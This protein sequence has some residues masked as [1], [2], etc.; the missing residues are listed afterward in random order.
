MAA[1]DVAATFTSPYSSPYAVLSPDLVIREVNWAYM[2]VT[3]R[4]R[5]ELLD[6]YFFDVFPG[7][8]E[9]ADRTDTQRVSGSLHRALETGRPDTLPLVRYD[10]ATRRTRDFQERYWGLVTVPVL[11]RD[12]AVD[13]LVLCPVDST[14]LVH[15]YT[16]ERKTALTLQEAMMPGQATV[17]DRMAARYRP[18]LSGS[19]LGGDWYD[20]VELR[21]GRFTAAVGDV[22]GCGLRA[23]AVMGR[24]RSALGALIRAD[25]DR[26]GSALAML[27]RYARTIE[28]ALGTT[29]ATVTVDTDAHTLTYGSAGHLPPMLL[30]PDGDVDTLD[31]ALSLPLSVGPLHR[32][33]P[34]ARYTYTSGSILV[35]Y[36]DGLVE[37]RGEVLD[38]GLDRLR[39][40]LTEHGALAT[41]ELANRLLADL[42]TDRPTEDDTALI[43]TAL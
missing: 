37:R 31:E 36:T 28:S 43:V 21:E 6:H 26:P 23:A 38:V 13:R 3:G 25:P 7:H 5:D 41:E 17:T 1:H 33:R 9:G 27:D 8:P 20:F 34:Q 42:L 30:R 2:W 35:L 15:T 16:R 4:A 24:L 14:A 19:N 22:V 12:G 11:D 32:T 10:I 29:V 39:R 40:S 18:A